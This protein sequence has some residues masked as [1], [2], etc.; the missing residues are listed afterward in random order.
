MTEENTNY[1]IA[2]MIQSF[3]NDY[4]ATKEQIAY[5]MQ[6]DG[7]DDYLLSDK[8]IEKIWVWF[9]KELL[10]YS[11]IGDKNIPASTSILHTNSG[12]GRVLEKAPENSTIFAFNTD[13]ICKRI[14]DFVCQDRARTGNYYSWVRDISQYFV[15]CNTDSSRKYSI[16]ITQPS[17]KSFFYK[18]VDCVGDAEKCEPIEYYTQ[19]SLHFAEE[20]G[21]LVVIFEPQERD[22]L[23]NIIEKLNVD[24][25]AYI[26]VPELKYASYEAV[27]LRKK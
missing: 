5:F 1:D 6:Y 19:K 2:Q 25:E 24:I 4:R 20:G 7:C 27:I 3:P 23:K 26:D 21:Y 13:Y 18:G 8:L 15:V 16:V 11:P 14:T 17:S 10:N 22:R 9:E 12:A